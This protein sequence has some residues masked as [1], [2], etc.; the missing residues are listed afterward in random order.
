MVFPHIAA[1]MAGY[2]KPLRQTAA[3]NHAFI[4]KN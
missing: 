2:D 4:T 1:L 3:F